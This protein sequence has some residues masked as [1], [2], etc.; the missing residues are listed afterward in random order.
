MTG[1]LAFA[2]STPG[3]I[4]LGVIAFFVWLSFHDAKVTNRAKAECQADTLRKTLTEV[5][6]QKDAADAL[7][8]DAEKQ[9]T[10]TE[11]EIAD[12]TRQRDQANA[13]QQG[14][15][16]ACEPVDGRVLERLRSIR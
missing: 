11:N 7:L 15:G 12:L 16:K 5:Q 4:I 14:K 8:A 2:T 13:A 3:K 10:A 9:K 6:R 1:L